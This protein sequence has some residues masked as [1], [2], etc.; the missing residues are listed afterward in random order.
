MVIAY[1]QSQPGSSFGF[2]GDLVD[3]WNDPRLSGTVIRW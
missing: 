1:R 3:D 2:G